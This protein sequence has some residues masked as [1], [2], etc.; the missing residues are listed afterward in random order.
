M[1]SALKLL[2]Q[3]LAA[4]QYSF[5]FVNSTLNVFYL[6]NF[7]CQ[8]HERLLGLLVFPSGEPVL[9]CP[10]MEVAR[11][12]SEGWT[13]EIIGYNDSEDPWQ[14][15][16]AI[17][18][19]RVGPEP[20]IAVEKEQLPLFRAEALQ[21]TFPGC[22]F[23]AVEAKLRELRNIKSD[24]EVQVL[25]EAAALADKAVEIGVAALA[26]GKTEMEVVAEI[27]YNMK[28]LGVA[29][30]SFPTMVLFGAKSAESH[31]SPGDTRLQA[32]DLVLFDLGVVHK[33]YCSDI[34]RTFAFKSITP[35]FEKIYEIT[36]KA[37][38]A[39]IAASAPGVRVGDIDKAARE[40]ITAAGYGE[41]FTHRVGHGLGIDVHEYPSMN[42]ENDDL[43][44]LGMA[45]TIE[46][47]IYL[48][49]R[50]GVRIEDDVVITADGCE[51]LTKFPKHLQIIG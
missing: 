3:W 41:Y 46:P 44:A 51:T 38:E 39:A 34:T 37:N 11:A 49:G 9:V 13:Y 20:V 50:G 25:R 17:V 16:A 33:G 18:G 35:E 21:K 7:Y 24:G 2:S 31:G 1:N 26:E 32:G 30:M 27:E 8:P 6:S 45:Y 5:A 40:V 29:R 10:L 48:P 42:G 43:L 4:N 36:L 14:K 12:K 19:D 28:K 22:R 15:I 47:G 23:S